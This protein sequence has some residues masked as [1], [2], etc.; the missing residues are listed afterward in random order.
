MS[1]LEKYYDNLPV[2]TEEKEKIIKEGTTPKLE[3]FYNNLKVEE[4]LE[5][6]TNEQSEPKKLSYVQQGVDMAVSGLQGAAK[7][8]S[9]LMDMPS[10]INTGI[11]FLT[12]KAASLVGVDAKQ[13]REENKEFY[14]IINRLP[15]SSG[16][17][18]STQPL[19]DKYLTYKPKTKKGEYIEKATEFALPGSIVG[20]G[21][22]AIYA[23]TGA[24]SGFTAKGV[25]DL[26]G[27]EGVGLGV[28]VGMN[29]ALDLYAAA[30]GNVANLVKDVIPSERLLKIARDKRDFAANRGLK[31]TAGESSG[32]RAVQSMEADVLTSKIGSALQ[33]EYY[34][35]RP[36]QLINFI[37]KFGQENGLITNNARLGNT[38]ILADLKKSAALL[39]ANRQKL[40]EKSGGLKFK[41]TYFNQVDVDN[42]INRFSLVESK[43]SDKATSTAILSYIARLKS[44]NAQGKN[45]HNV[46]KDIRDTKIDLQKNFQTTPGSDATIK[47]YKEIGDDLN[48]LLS[49]NTDFKKAQTIYKKFTEAYVKPLNKTKIFKS[50][51]SARWT[52]DYETVGKVYRLFSS[53]KL[54]ASDIRKL[55]KS[56]NKTENKKAWRNIMSGY[57]DNL[58]QKSQIDNLSEGLNIGTV[59]NKA[60]TGSPSAR[61]NVGEMFYQV[62]LN[63]GYKGSR[64]DIVKAVDSFSA[65]LRAS[66]N[67][68]KMGSPTAT[69]QAS[70]E[71]MSKTKASFITK[72]PPGFASIDDWFKQRA[73]TQNSK[74]LSEALLS[75][76]G[77]DELINLAQNWKDPGKAIAAVRALTIGSST[78]DEDLD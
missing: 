60:L 18:K 28:G 31:L 36:E 52:D 2:N 6:E 14:S 1:S 43:V 64:T 51:E 47:A 24:A 32:S 68:A 70:Q 12:D 58:F 62:A 46:Y 20:K 16:S 78:F 26:S 54:N 25:E 66:G 29:V 76:K 7:G 63:R 57:V 30:R 15:F 42:L 73:Y 75:D 55:A 5:N 41:Q 3:N 4:E 34:A 9:Y 74:I 17:A 39:Q 50:I 56:F 71:A 44:S 27:S 59:L 13:L 49:K 72:F 48:S 61:N 37:K 40:W 69:R 53:D 77:I 67:Y 35:T 8:T 38:R 10:L 45:L 11:E 19:R 22:R 65:V 23:A 21:S 33:T